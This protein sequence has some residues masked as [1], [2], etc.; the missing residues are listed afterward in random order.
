MYRPGSGVGVGKVIAG[1]VLGLGAI[2]GLATGLGV[3][4][5]ELTAKN[6]KISNLQDEIDTNY[7]ITKDVNIDPPNGFIN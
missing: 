3:V 6:S 2:A 7:R 1:A 5:S 4:G